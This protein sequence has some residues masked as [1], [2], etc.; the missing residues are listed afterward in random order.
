MAYVTVA[1]I[2]VGAGE[3]FQ[4]DGAAFTKLGATIDGVEVA[5]EPEIGE[6]EVDQ[7]KDAALLFNQGVTVTMRTNLAEATLANLALAWGYP[8]TAVATAGDTITFNL[9]DPDEDLTERRIRVVGKAPKTAGGVERTRT[10]EARRCI[11][12]EG[13]T[14][15]LKK[16]EATVFPVSFRLLPDPSYSGSEYGTIVDTV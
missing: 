3:I 6:V 8:A 12:V 9:S 10:Y 4:W 13:S 11:S 7:L 16:N 2:I 14:H 15:G 5:F 1:N